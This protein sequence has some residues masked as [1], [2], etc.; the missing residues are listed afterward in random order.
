[1]HT[2]L[3]HLFGFVGWRRGYKKS[4]GEKFS[5]LDLKSS[6]LATTTLK[7]DAP[8]NGKL[9]KS[10]H[11]ELYT[12]RLALVNT[13][14]THA[15]H[16]VTLQILPSTRQTVLPQQLGNR[17]LGGMVVFIRT[18]GTS[19]IGPTINLLARHKNSP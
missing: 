1:M 8:A 15:L 4:R 3:K 17:H 13:A 16:G 5:P 19:I 7:L 10:R 9:L 14:T 11:R 2:R 6:H 18:L 12:L